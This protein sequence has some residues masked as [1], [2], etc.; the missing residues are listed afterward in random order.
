MESSDISRRISTMRDHNRALKKEQRNTNFVKLFYLDTSDYLI[1]SWLQSEPCSHGVVTVLVSQK[2]P[3]AGPAG[4]AA[5]L[6]QPRSVIRGI[7]RGALGRREWRLWR[8]VAREL[9]ELSI[10]VP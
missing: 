4:F 3:S 5:T 7:D 10:P 9:A 6:Q 1:V 8:R 2:E